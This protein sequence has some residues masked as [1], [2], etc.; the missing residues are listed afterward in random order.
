MGGHSLLATQVVSRLRG[1]FGVELPLRVLFEEPTVAGVARRVEQLRG[2]SAGR[3]IPPIVAVSREERLPLSFAQQRLWFID[4]FYPENSLY[5]VNAAVRLRGDLHVIALEQAMTALVE[6]H[7]ALRTRFEVVDGEP[8]QV[9]EPRASVRLLYEGLSSRENEAD[10]EQEALERLQMLAG[11]PYDLRNG[12][13]VRMMLLRLADNDHVLFLGMH[14]IVSDQWSMRILVD[15]FTALYAAFRRGEPSTLAG[16]AIQY[17]DFAVWQR[18]RLEG[19]ITD[20]QLSYWRRQLEGLPA[21]LELP[22]DFARPREASFQTESYLFDLPEELVSPLRMLWRDYAATSFMG[23]LAAFSVLLSYY[24]AQQDIAIGTSVANRNLLDTERVVGFFVNQLT[25][26]CDLSG[27][28]TFVELLSRIRETALGA[29]LNQDL[30][31]EKVVSA[32]RPDRALNRSPLFQVKYEFNPEARS[33]PTLADID[34]SLFDL[35]L[36]PF[37]NDLH[38]LLQDR[39][40]GVSGTVV[41]D[42]NLFLPE[43]IARLAEDYRIL[44]LRIRAN[45]ADKLSGLMKSLA[46]AGQARQEKL[47]RLH[48]SAFQKK[49]AAR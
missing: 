26:R 45:P 27:D 1:I 20:K 4:Q 38:L 8:L 18:Q 17:A 13:L 35:K 22:A 42:R 41:Y 25:L 30:P 12:P 16:P 21:S 28:P 7:E 23:F 2:G 19:G 34:V 46:D 29:Y 33:L 37:R 44:L 48:V 24:S 15:D 36:S 9:I 5:N 3:S 49:L 40:V 31:F 14:H 39:R 10:R 47:N 6:R 32:L 43:R 11:Q